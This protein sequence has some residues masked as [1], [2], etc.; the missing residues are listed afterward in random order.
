MPRYQESIKNFCLNRKAFTGMETVERKE[1]SEFHGWL[2][3]H[4][5]DF[6]SI[7]L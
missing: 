5:H 3:H 6:G 1:L 4:A 2:I 7:G